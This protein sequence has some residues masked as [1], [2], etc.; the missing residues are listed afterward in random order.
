MHILVTRPAA[1][2]DTLKRPLEAMGH[3]VS[4]APMIEISFAD[5]DPLNLTN[6]AAIIATSRNGLKALEQRRETLPP[7]IWQ[8]RLFAVGPGTAALAR[9]L[10]FKDVIEGPGSAAELVPVIAKAVDPAAGALVHLSGDHAA[11]DILAAL[12]PLGYGL[13]Q[14]VVY[15]TVAATSCSPAVEKDFAHGRIDAVILMSP[16]SAQT[17]VS[18]VTSRGLGDAARNVRYLCLSDA[19]ARQLVAPQHLAPHLGAPQLGDWQ[20]LHVKVALKPNLD[21]ILVLL[22]RPEEP[23]R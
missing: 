5:P 19:V 14:P 16:K 23:F 13:R 9:R 7:E 2:A 6:C 21:E 17:F 3:R 12:T 4:L 10:G 18:L 20:P 11:F 1:D 22:S 8:L 15:R